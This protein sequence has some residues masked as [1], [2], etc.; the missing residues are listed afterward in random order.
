M[1]NDEWEISEVLSNHFSRG[2]KKMR[3]IYIWTGLKIEI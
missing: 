2:L 3:R 1:R